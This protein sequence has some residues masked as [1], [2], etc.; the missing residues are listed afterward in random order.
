MSPPGLR[1]RP[2]RSPLN[3]HTGSA[4]RG[5]LHADGLGLVGREGRPRERRAR[6]TRPRAPPSNG[7]PLVVTIP[8]QVA[9]M[10]RLLF[11]ALAACCGTLCLAAEPP[12]ALPRS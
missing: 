4:H 3:Q 2:P 7:R 1:E 12:Q 10:K 11:V 8:S 5:G 6:L 9:S